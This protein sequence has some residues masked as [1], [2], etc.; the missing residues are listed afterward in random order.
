LKPTYD[1]AVKYLNNF[2]QEIKGKAIVILP[3]DQL[4]FLNDNL[5]NLRHDQKD[6]EILVDIY[7]N[8]KNTYDFI[9][10]RSDKNE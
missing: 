8:I 9:S 3:R 1:E 7:F 10:A 4:K 2:A 5:L 6:N